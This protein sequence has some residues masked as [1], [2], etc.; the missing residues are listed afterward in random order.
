MGFTPVASTV[1][2]A[3]GLRISLLVGQFAAASVRGAAAELPLSL[4][5]GGAIS[6]GFPGPL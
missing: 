1:S 6:Y 3:W 5:E 2:A 4:G